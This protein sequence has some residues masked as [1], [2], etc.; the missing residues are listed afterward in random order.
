MTGTLEEIKKERER[1]VAF[2]F[3][4]AEIFMELDSA[5][6]ILFEGGAVERIGAEKTSSLVGN[7]I[8][9]IIDPDDVEV[10][11]A[12]IL[13]LQYKGRIG[14]I[15]IRFLTENNRSLALRVFALGMPGS[16]AR[17]FLSLRSAPLGGRGTS[18]SSDNEETGLLG[19]NAFIELA[20]KTMAAS[21]SENNVYMTAIEVE[22]LEDARKNF[23]P[24]FTQSLLHKISAHLTTLSLD[25]ELAGQLS[26][27]HFA[28][29]HRAK[30]D[31]SHL[32]ESLKTVDANVTLKSTYSTVAANGTG[33]PEDQVIR[34]LSYILSKFCE[35]P[36]SVNFESLSNAFN[37][38]A[39][40]AQLRVT[41]MRSMI[42]TGNFKIAF[43]PVVSL[44]NGT[45]LHNEVL[46]RFNDS[47]S[48]YTPLEV[49]QFAE[50][51]GVIEEFDLALCRKAIDYI[52]KMKK[53]GT[54]VRLSVNLSGR[55]FDNSRGIEPLLKTLLA[56]KDISHSLL[57][58]L[59]DTATIKNLVKVEAV[60]NDL[61]AAGFKLCLDDFGAGA[62]GYQYLRAF[63]V[64]YVKIDGSYVKDIVRKDYKPTFLLSII[65]LCDDLG[66]KTIGEHVETNFQADFLRS[67]GVHYGQGF[68]YGKPD[69]APRTN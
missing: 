32:S 15:P 54:P 50:D 28:F 40:E 57:L 58:E 47:T 46:S 35:N 18:D 12:L 63:N 2:A 26:D 44:Q 19:Q 29:L 5:G 64:D 49:I 33:V 24:K 37:V 6:N 8:E 27:K 65:R 20:S 39:S 56:A 41:N 21:P 13:H 30:N 68:H 1:F 61:K 10:Y 42:E 38:M 66:I 59:T 51:I 53:L 9:N 17:T 7:N 34:T 23:G 55:T 22:G 14:P 52:R 48:D 60:L 69:Y 36:K 11:K 45:I 3:A 62:S 16:D 67:I 4:A 25:G 43:Q 31:G